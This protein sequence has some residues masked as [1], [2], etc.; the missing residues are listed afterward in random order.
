[1][2]LVYRSENC[3]YSAFDTYLLPRALR[4]MYLK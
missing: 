2:P 3:A 4:E 1:M